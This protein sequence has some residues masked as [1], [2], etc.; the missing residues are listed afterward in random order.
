MIAHAERFHIIG[1]WA[2]VQA[3]AF[4]L[5]AVALSWP[6]IDSEERSLNGEKFLSYIKIFVQGGK[7]KRSM[8]KLSTIFVDKCV[9]NV[10]KQVVNMDL[11]HF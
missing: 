4:F 1:A 8:C 11:T 6:F 3:L 10:Q 9:E 7:I 2:S 5:T